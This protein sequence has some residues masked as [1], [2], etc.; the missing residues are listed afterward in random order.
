MLNEDLFWLDFAFIYLSK[1]ILNCSHSLFR[2][3][4]LLGSTILNQHTLTI[5]EKNTH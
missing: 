2:Q 4:Q 3:P 1:S 5:S